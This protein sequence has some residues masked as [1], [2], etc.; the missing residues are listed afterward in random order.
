[1][2]SG[3]G[4]AR[5]GARETGE[6]GVPNVFVTLYTDPNG[7][8]DPKDGQIIERVR[9]DANGVYQFNSI[10]AN[11]LYVIALDV[12]NFVPGGPL[13]RTV[14]TRQSN[15][16]PAYGLLSSKIQVRTPATP[17]RLRA[18]DAGTDGSFGV[19]VNCEPPSCLA[20]QRRRL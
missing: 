16:S 8:G 12:K 2:V 20:L 5:N 7:D 9:T 11:E 19:I 1:M 13:W 14:S 4:V 17:L 15:F 18:L 6:P 10:Y 3:G